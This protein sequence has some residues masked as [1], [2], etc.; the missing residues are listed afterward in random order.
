MASRLHV[1]IPFLLVALL[2]GGCKDRQITSYRAPKDPA[3]VLP[4]ERA[5]AGTHLPA[6]H[7]PIDSAQLPSDHPPIGASQAQGG[8]MAATPV[9]TGG[10]NLT[11]TAP[12]H[13]I[14]RPASSMRKGTFIVKGDDGREAELAISAFPGDTGG[15]HPNLNRWRG[16]LGLPPAPDAELDAALQHID[17]GDLHFEVIDIAG[18]PNGNPTRMLGAILSRPGETWFFKLTGP[19][20][21]VAREKPAFLDFLK[22]VRA[23]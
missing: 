15:L 9:P 20:A 3:P 12:A 19:D 4:T 23:P 10:G 5:S 2:A 18:T 1:S 8:S 22:T 13:W 17:G 6:D 7:P 14:A 11:W 16:Q 21:L